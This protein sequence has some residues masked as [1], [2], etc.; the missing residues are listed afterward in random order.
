MIQS[1]DQDCAGAMFEALDG[2]HAVDV[3]VLLDEATL[4]HIAG[5]SGLAGDYQGD[6]VIGELVGRL[7][8]LTGGTLR[9]GPARSTATAR[10][11]AAVRGSLLAERHGRRLDTT[12]EV[13][14]DVEAG[15]IREVW[16]SDLQEPAFDD[17]WS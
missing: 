8:R 10:G 14:V 3:A 7:I 11:T 13:A 6:E 1:V 5:A 4:L 2:R 15:I 16:I 17:F 12:V 9:C